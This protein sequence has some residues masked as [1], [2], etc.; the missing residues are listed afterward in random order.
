MC[1]MS[2]IEA[3]APPGY[4]KL[5][6]KLQTEKNPAKFRKLVEKINRLLRYYEKL[7]GS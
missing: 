2:H 1:G 6:A 7:S 5:C 3:Q 4:L